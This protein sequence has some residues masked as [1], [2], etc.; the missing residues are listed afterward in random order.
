MQPVSTEFGAMNNINRIPSLQEIHHRS[1]MLASS[2]LD[3]PTP[4]DDFLH[5]ILSSVPS[6]AGPFPWA[7][8]D[9]APPHLEDQSASALAS[10]MR[11][12]QISNGAAKALTM[13][14]QQQQQQQQLF[15]N[16]ANGLLSP[17]GSDGSL[18][19]DVGDGNSFMSGHPV[20]F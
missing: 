18:L 6:S 8:D 9:H 4:H 10:K 1:Q 7:D 14:Q 13:L 19:H 2:Q 15:L 3:P 16:A 20:S 12:H 5:Q 17:T 11:Q